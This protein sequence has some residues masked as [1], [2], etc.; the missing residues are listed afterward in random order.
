MRSLLLSLPIAA[1]VASAMA[2]PVA[3][4][5]TTRVV[6]NDGRGS[7]AS[8]DGSVRAYRSIQGAVDDSAAGDTVV[9]CPGSYTGRVVV[10]QA[11]DRLTIRASRH[12][13]ATVRVGSSSGENSIITIRKGA[14]GV[15]IQD[16]KVRY[17]AVRAL[18]AGI[19]P[20]C[21]V[22]AGIQVDGQRALLERNNIAATGKGT[23]SCGMRYGI[24]VG[25]RADGASATVR[26]NTVKDTMAG[27]IAAGGTATR[28]SAFRNVVRFWHDLAATG[29]IPLSARAAGWN[30]LRPAGFRGAGS[31]I[32]IFFGA[33]GSI[34]ENTVEGARTGRGPLSSGTRLYAATGI[35]ADGTGKATV[36]G[37]RVYRSGVNL[38]I[39]GLNPIPVQAA[40]FPVTVSD[41]TALSGNVGIHVLGTG[42]T[43]DGNDAHGN[44]GGIWA[45]DASTGN[46]F[47]DNDARSN[48]EM[49]CLDDSSD[50][51]PTANTWTDNVG[52]TDDPDGLC[53]SPF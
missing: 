7:P 14:T 52:F 9:V 40:S 5:G 35:I 3:A 41:N 48:L 18:T 17:P 49:D 6:D 27:G 10:G 44:G 23:L 51:L 20:A 1:L 45:G 8:C 22:V 29:P 4:A 42:A 36:T 50:T 43:I 2:A 26:Y 24:A 16:L 46:T 47:V 30:G 39:G 53:L 31:G 33:A 19:G 38:S 37:N 28:L 25:Y 21:G 32:D 13:G 11:K 34:R 15:V 12:L